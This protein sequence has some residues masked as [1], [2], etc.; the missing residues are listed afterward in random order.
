MPRKSANGNGTVK[1]RMV[2]RG[3]GSTYRRWYARITVGWD[4]DGKRIR[5]DGPLRKTQSEALADLAELQRQASRGLLST[6]SAQTLD[7]YL[8]TWLAQVI[9]TNKFRTY[10]TYESDLRKHVRPHLGQK[11]L[12]HIKKTDVQNM[13]NQVFTDARAAGHDGAASVRKARA[14]LR[15]AL[16]DAIDLDILEVNPCAGIKVPSEKVSEIEV[17]TPDEAKAYFEAARAHPLYPLFYTAITT[18]MRQGELCGLKWQDLEVREDGARFNIRRTLVI[19]PKRFQDVAAQN[20]E[21]EHVFGTYYFNSPK[22]KGSM[23]S[24]TVPTDTIR[25]LALHKARLEQRAVKLGERWHDFGLVFPTGNGTPLSPNNVL[26]EHKE[27]IERSGVRKISFHDIQ[28]T[29]AS[30]LLSAGVDIGTVSE[31][32]RHSRKSTTLDRYVHVVESQRKR[33][34]MTLEELFD[35]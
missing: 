14:A 24:V 11:Q 26:R 7:E 31:R 33:A 22:T 6:D 1:K 18:G 3:D 17:W 19:V 21:L 8:D 12:R 27:L 35:E 20:P 15:K 28:D 16:Q 13:A 5:Q 29:H 2:K 9:R 30:R 34:T 4:A 23:G 10:Q 25:L 32:L